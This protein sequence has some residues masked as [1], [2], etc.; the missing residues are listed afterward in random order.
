MDKPTTDIVTVKTMDT[1]CTM[2]NV[3]YYQKISKDKVL[4]SYINKLDDEIIASHNLDIVKILNKYKDIES[5]SFDACSIVI[6]AAVTAYGRVEISK[7][8]LNI[9][10]LKEVIYIIVIK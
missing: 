4:I 6:S 3:K 9:F 10:L 1:I 8:K 7:R 5:T 2:K